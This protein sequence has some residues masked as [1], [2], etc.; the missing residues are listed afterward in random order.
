MARL[1]WFVAALFATAACDGPPGGFI[2][3][4]AAALDAAAPDAPLPPDA[5]VPTLGP[6][7]VVSDLHIA[8]FQEDLHTFSLLGQ[9]LDP[10]IAE[11]IASG[12]L[13]IGLEL[14]SLDDPSGQADD[15]VSVG[16]YNLRDSDMDPANNFDPDAPETFATGP[17]AFLPGGDPTIH[18]T[19]ASITNGRLEAA[20]PDSLALP[21]IPFPFQN[22]EL[23]GRLRAT[24]D[25]SAVRT[26]DDGRLRGAVPA[27]LLRF[28]PNVTMGLCTGSTMLDALAAGCPISLQP[29]V[30]LDGDG[31][32]RYFD[33]L[34]D[35]DAGTSQ[36][37]RIDRC[38]DGDG[39][40]ILGT[41]CV[42]DSRMADGYRL[43]FVVEGV[44]A[45]VVAP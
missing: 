5:M 15:M 20:G 33:D 34:G 16:F 8:G 36:D 39:T 13:L 27:S 23:E 19:E 7:L 17:G 40:E 6:S 32:E 24:S 11:Q 31:L 10:Q 38:V 2:A 3:L 25:E 45:I 30:D 37:G 44:R 9:L 35:A 42:S 21:G 41:D 4:D 18:F 43:I 22:P 12:T 26:L 28:L 14:R 1:A 29:D